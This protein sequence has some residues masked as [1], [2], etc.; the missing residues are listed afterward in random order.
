MWWYVY[1]AADPSNLNERFHSPVA[2]VLPWLGG[3]LCLPVQTR[4]TRWNNALRGCTPTVIHTWRLKEEGR[5][6]LRDNPTL[7]HS[8]NGT[9]VV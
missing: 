9:A 2:L 5:E 3:G 6:E 7:A 1:S 4:R 8:I